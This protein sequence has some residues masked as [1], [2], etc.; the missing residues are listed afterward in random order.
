LISKPTNGDQY[1]LRADHNFSARNSI[2]VRYFRDDSEE[3]FQFGNI[4][5]YA[6]NRRALIATNWALQDTH[7]FSPT[8]LNEFRIG[9]N[10]ID[11]KVFVLDTTKLSDLGAVFPGALQ[12]S[13]IG[14]SGYFSLATDEPFGEDGS[15]YQIGNT[16]R[17]FRG[18]HSISV[19]GEF[20]RTDMF[21]RGSSANQ[22]VFSFDGSATKNAFADFLIGKPISL[23]QASR[24]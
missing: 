1:L 9:V 23:D 8:L 15:I 16:V 24:Y 17:W 11:S 3:F 10:R 20:E 21:N 22:G 14:V 13:N 12:L 5:P 19:G 4:A 7:T 18:R 6:P 2:N